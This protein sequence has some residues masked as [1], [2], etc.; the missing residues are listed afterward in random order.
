MKLAFIIPVCKDF[1]YVKLSYPLIK[2]H[3]PDSDVAIMSDG[4]DDPAIESFCVKNNIKYFFFKHSHNNDTPGGFTRNLFYVSTFLDFD[5]LIKADPDSRVL[6]TIETSE[7]LKD[8]IF[9]TLMK[10]TIRR[11]I[12]HPNGKLNLIRPDFIQNGI[13]GIGNNVVKKIINSKYF[14]DDKHLREKL[15]HYLSYG[16]GQ[17]ST[18]ALSSELL[19]AIACNNLNIPLY[20]HKDFYSI[21]YMKPLKLYYYDLPIDSSEAEARMKE[22]KFVHPIYE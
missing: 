18:Y 20:N 3:Y 11:E 5:L 12:R 9:G 21:I 1:N 17:P 7:I 6:G 13:F 22:A 8:K 4:N 2:K 15:Y 10:S 16:M 14:E 19:M